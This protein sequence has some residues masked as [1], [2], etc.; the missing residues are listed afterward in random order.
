MIILTWRK[1]KNQ[2]SVGY[3]HWRGCVNGV[4]LYHIRKDADGDFE[5]P[6]LYPRVKQKTLAMAKHKAYLHANSTWK[7]EGTGVGLR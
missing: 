3:W 2:D 1:L 6:G 5:L 4:G 7:R